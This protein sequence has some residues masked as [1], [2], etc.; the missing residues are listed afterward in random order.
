MVGWL[1]E[2]GLRKDGLQSSSSSK[3]VHALPVSKEAFSIDIVVD[4][5]D[6]IG[7][8]REDVNDCCSPPRINRLKA[9]ASFEFVKSDM[10]RDLK[11]GRGSSIV[12]NSP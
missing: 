12:I 9:L 7:K 8:N 5:L 4:A 3:V 10:F 1:R 2:D 11:F 6:D